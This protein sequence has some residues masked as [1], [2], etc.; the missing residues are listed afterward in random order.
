M[1]VGGAIA[2]PSGTEHGTEVVKGQSKILELPP[3]IRVSDRK[4]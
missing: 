1:V 2:I 3:E 4:I